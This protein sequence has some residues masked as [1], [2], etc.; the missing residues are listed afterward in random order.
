MVKLA[1]HKNV[2]LGVAHKI[3]A[4]F[5]TLL[6]LTAAACTSA[7]KREPVIPEEYL[8]TSTAPA[9]GSIEDESEAYQWTG[10]KYDDPRFAAELDNAPTRPDE[11]GIYTDQWVADG[12]L[13]QEKRISGNKIRTVQRKK[14]K[15]VRNVR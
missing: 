11:V 10:K 2:G 4:G 7:P 12:S 6:C 13:R 15:R 9:F 14:V 5:L 3:V 1:L 8:E